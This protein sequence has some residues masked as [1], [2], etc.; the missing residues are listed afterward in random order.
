MSGQYSFR[1]L[2]LNRQPRA[3]HPIGFDIT[4]IFRPLGAGV[5]THGRRAQEEDAVSFLHL[6]NQL[7]DCG[8][9]DFG[10]RHILSRPF[11]LQGVNCQVQQLVGPVGNAKGVS[12]NALGEIDYPDVENH[13]RRFVAAA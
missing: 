8:E 5:A 2:L 3:R 11:P 9:I 12:R 10:I 7:F 13:R 4:N 6:N 1:L